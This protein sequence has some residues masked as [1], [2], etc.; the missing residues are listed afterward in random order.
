MANNYIPRPDTRFHAWQNNLA[1]Y[2]KGHLADLGLAAGVIRAGI[3]V[4]VGDPPPAPLPPAARHRK[5]KS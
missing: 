4:K 5:A 2:V 1:T 3:W